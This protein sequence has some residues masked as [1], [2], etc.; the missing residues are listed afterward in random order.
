[1][2][3]SGSAKKMVQGMSA[4]PQDL[5]SH[6]GH[7][8]GGPATETKPRFLRRWHVEWFTQNSGWSRYIDHNPISSKEKRSIFKGLKGGTGV[9][10]LFE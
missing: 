2:P 8:N 10:K 9:E 3:E 6:R 4:A 1:M 5:T 7:P